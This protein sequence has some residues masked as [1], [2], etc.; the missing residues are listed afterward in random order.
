MQ[1]ISVEFGR[2]IDSMCRGSKY[3]VATI[4]HLSRAIGGARTSTK[5]VFEHSCSNLQHVFAFKAQ[6]IKFIFSYD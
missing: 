1:K 5:Y 3:S 4:S 2:L 6:I